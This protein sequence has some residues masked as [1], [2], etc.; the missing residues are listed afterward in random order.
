VEERVVTEFSVGLNPQLLDG[1]S[2]FY[3]FPWQVANESLIDWVRPLKPL[4]EF[5]SPW[6]QALGKR[7]KRFRI[8]NVRHCELMFDSTLIDVK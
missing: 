3:G 2:T 5:V 8:W 7:G 6:R 1:V 4:G